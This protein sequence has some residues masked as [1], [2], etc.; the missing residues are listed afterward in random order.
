MIFTEVRI[1]DKELMPLETP[2]ALRLWPLTTP[3]Q[4]QCLFSGYCP[5]LDTSYPNQFG[6]DV[7]EAFVY[8]P[9]YPAGVKFSHKENHFS[10]E[11]AAR[12][13]CGGIAT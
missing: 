8:S 1:S 3:L 6:P 4:R 10:F 12:G 7:I 9:H 5:V 2:S 11:T 13:H